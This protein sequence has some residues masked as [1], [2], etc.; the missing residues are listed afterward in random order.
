SVKGSGLSSVKI[1][2]K[3]EV[4][5]ATAF[6]DAISKF[7]KYVKDGNLPRNE[8]ITLLYDLLEQSSDFLELNEESKL[9]KIK[10]YD[11]R[12]FEAKRFSLKE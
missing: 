12:G 7:V 5:E 3:V 1:N 9:F 4:S 8:S 10:Y 6:K 11:S 2:I